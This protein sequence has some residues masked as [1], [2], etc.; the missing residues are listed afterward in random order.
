MYLAAFSLDFALFS[1]AMLAQVS[2]ALLLMQF[3]MPLAYGIFGYLY[4]RRSVVNDW[5]H[6]L[7]ATAVWVVL[8]L[9]VSSLVTVLVYGK[10]L[11]TLFTQDAFTSQILNIALMLIAGLFARHKTIP[12]LPEGLEV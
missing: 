4:F 10:G 2:S 8:S 9:V 6:L 7:C 12:P 3:I 5:N 11:D 1:A